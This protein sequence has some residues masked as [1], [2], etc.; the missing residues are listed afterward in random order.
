MCAEPRAPTHD[1]S[2]WMANS[3]RRDAFSGE[4]QPFLG[5]GGEKTHKTLNC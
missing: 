3:S 1:T 4:P 2:A 5:S